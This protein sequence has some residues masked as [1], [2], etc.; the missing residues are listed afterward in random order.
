MAR[1]LTSVEQTLDSKAITE[2]V[3]MGR[4]VDQMLL[5]DLSQ[6]D[7]HTLAMNWREDT[8]LAEVIALHL[9]ENGI[10]QAINYHA[11]VHA[12]LVLFD[13]PDDDDDGT[14]EVCPICGSV[15]R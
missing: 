13:E 9:T 12:G 10:A 2:A 15:L 3:R 8:K 4:G 1:Q 11:M 7:A 14:P 6:K 5:R